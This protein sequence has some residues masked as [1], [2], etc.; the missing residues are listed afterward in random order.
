MKRVGLPS[1]INVVI[2]LPYGDLNKEERRAEQLEKLLGAFNTLTEKYENNNKYHF[3]VVVSEQVEPSK[4]FNRGLLINLSYKYFVENVGT[5][6]LLI[7]H[8]IDMIPNERMFAQYLQPRNSYS[9]VPHNSK[10]LKKEYGFKALSGA[11]VYMTTP[12]AFTRANGF[13]NNFWG[14]GGEDN[15]F[16]ARYIRL[17]V[18]LQRNYEGDYVSTD[19]QRTTQKDKIAYLK[20][21]KLR[22]MC[23]WELV[24]AD[25][26][27]WGTNGVRQL[28][29]SLYEMVSSDVLL[30]KKNMTRVWLRVKLRAHDIRMECSNN[31]PT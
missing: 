22:N 30:Q 23:A 29:D 21:N 18:Q 15:A 13:P 3:F 27:K 20:K 17:K 10:T 25:K 24:K 31:T 26:I 28:G 16:H 5:P 8:D 1:R 19:A 4:Y 11:A 2:I 6:S 14:W 12:A 7:F 9:L